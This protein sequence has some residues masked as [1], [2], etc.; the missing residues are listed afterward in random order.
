MMT[1][2]WDSCISR[3]R[4]VLSERH[5]LGDPCICRFQRGLSKRHEL[6]AYAFV[7]IVVV[8]VFGCHS[9]CGT[10]GFPTGFVGHWG[11]PH[12]SFGCVM[13]CVFSG[14]RLLDRI[15]CGMWDELVLCGLFSC[16]L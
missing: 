9:S 7:V 8:L 4:W 5:G 12:G 16:A 3:Y 14:H 11:F 13:V 2:V 6:M 15:G 1:G 10:G